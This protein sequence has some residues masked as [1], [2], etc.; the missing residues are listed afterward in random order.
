M[1]EKNC[2]ASNWPRYALLRHWNHRNRYRVQARA[3]GPAQRRKGSLFKAGPQC[4]SLLLNTDNPVNGTRAIKGC[5]RYVVSGSTDRGLVLARHTCECRVTR[6]EV[7]HFVPCSAV[8]WLRGNRA[9]AQPPRSLNSSI[10]CTADGTNHV[11]FRTIHSS[12]PQHADSPNYAFS[13]PLAVHNNRAPP[14]RVRGL[15]SILF[16]VRPIATDRTVASTWER[17]P[18]SPCGHIVLHNP[19]RFGTMYVLSRRRPRRDRAAFA[20]NQ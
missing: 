15:G 19:L 14:A 2:L 5:G 17:P 13:Q 18:Y 12:L 4:Q 16:R 11:G 7:T 8:R 1:I 9:N 3:S 20:Q 10:S 6:R